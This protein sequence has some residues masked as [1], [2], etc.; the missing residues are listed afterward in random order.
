MKELSV[1]QKKFLAEFLGNFAIAWL[2]GAVV[3]PFFSGALLTETWRLNI[4][5]GAGIAGI[6]LFWAFVTV[7][8]VES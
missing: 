4:T 5:A 2:V 1:G 7:K 3:S 8:E 6:F